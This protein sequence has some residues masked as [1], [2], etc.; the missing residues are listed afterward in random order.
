[1]VGQYEFENTPR[2]LF[3]LRNMAKVANAAHAPFVG[4][5]RRASLSPAWGREREIA[6]IKDLDGL[7]N[8]PRFGKW[9]EFR[10]SEEAAYIGLAFP[11]Y[12]LRLPWHP[13]TNPASACTSPKRPRATAR[14][15]CGATRRSS[16]RATWSSPSRAQ[17]GAST[18]AVPKGGG[19]VEGL[20]V[21]TFNLRGQDEIRP[22]VE[23]TIP[24]TA[25]S[26]SP[27]GGFIPL[28]Y[29]KDS[30]DACLLQ[31]AVGQ[32]PKSSRIRRTPRTRSWSATWPIRS[33]SPA[34][35]TM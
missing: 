4:A 3:W 27:K 25:S 28:V 13:D 2:D 18:S 1:M 7:L 5:C 6:A 10:N 8:N 16:W 29:R 22:P 19:M 15:T 26:S 14:S 21:D 23:V 31:R 11:R 24:T 9:R 12:V 35:R 17:A 32:G 33:R 34:S 20:P 30:A